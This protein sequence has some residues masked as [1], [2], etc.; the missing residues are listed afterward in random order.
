MLAVEFNKSKSGGSAGT[1]LV[2]LHQMYVLDV[3]VV[4]EAVV[5][6]GLSRQFGVQLTHKDRLFF[7]L[8]LAREVGC[9]LDRP[10]G[11]CTKSLSA[12][13]KSEG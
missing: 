3:S 9:P 10:A 12:K 4:L 8:V 13:K 7:D 2:S 1:H 6:Q 5:Q 11:G